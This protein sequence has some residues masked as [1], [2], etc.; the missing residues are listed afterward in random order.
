[1][2]TVTAAGMS[3]TRNG[4]IVRN[5]ETG[6]IERI[7][8]E[9]NGIDIEE[10]AK[11]NSEV[12]KAQGKPYEIKI[13]KD[14][15]TKSALDEMRN[16]LGAVEVM[17]KS[18]SNPLDSPL[19]KLDTNASDNL[20]KLGGVI[21]NTSDGKEF[22]NVMFAAANDSSIIGTSYKIVIEQL[23]SKDKIVG[24]V[25][26][27]DDETALN[28]DGTITINGVEVDIDGDMN[29]KEIKNVIVSNVEDINV[30]I[31]SKDGSTDYF[32]SLSAKDYAK[33][34]TMSDTLGTMTALGVSETGKDAKSLS[35]IIKLRVTD[36]PNDDIE[37][38]RNKNV[39]ITDVVPGVI[40]LK[41]ADSDRV[42]TLDFVDDKTSVVKSLE[43][44][45]DTWNELVVYYGQQTKGDTKTNE[46]AED[47]NLFKNEF[48][49]GMMNN[50]KSA[51]G[52]A[53]TLDKNPET[54]NDVITA[55]IDFGI[56]IEPD[57]TMSID[58]KKLDTGLAERYDD[59]KRAVGEYGN[60]TN[61]KFKVWAFP[62]DM[63]EVEAK[64]ITV[65][66]NKDASG[67]ET[68]TI[69]LNG[70]TVNVS[71]TDVAKGLIK[72]PKGTKFEGLKIG[73]IPLVGS[74]SDIPNNTSDSSTIK[75]TRGAFAKFAEVAKSYTKETNFKDEKGL[76]QLEMERLD[77]EKEKNES[78]I[79]EI[80]SRAERQLA[81][82]RMS[83]NRIYE[84]MMEYQ[85]LDFMLEN[86]IKSL[87]QS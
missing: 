73:Y 42:I 10:M 50:L 24:S 13:E 74:E 18:L 62:K 33:P 58:M 15:K 5:E 68:A 53:T 11:A 17:A 87:E 44:L 22:G 23:A 82:D 35:A 70:E 65:T 1:M 19:N 66:Y 56:K 12:I 29:L 85:N 9:V 31:T 38:V 45:R 41:V 2:P 30:E 59:F 26:F 61:P 63:S 84:Q 46:A 48:V 64:D 39:G 16:K 3:N 54:G 21:G 69:T 51:L 14:A 75:F 78:K 43:H 60:S 28:I 79:E 57:W 71:G 80:E 4:K 67:V 8:Q 40:D 72:G 36:D 81:R 83:W 20:L 7:T 47:A 32:L 76:I 37:L 25:T 86:I 49:K 6:K 34:I 77:K 55:L 27:A 52:T